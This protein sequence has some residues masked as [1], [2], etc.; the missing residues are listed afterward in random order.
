MWLAIWLYYQLVYPRTAGK[1]NALEGKTIKTTIDATGV[2]SS[3]DTTSSRFAW[4][5]IEW[6]DETGEHYFL[7]P[8][9]LVVLVIPKRAL[10][11]ADEEQR[12]T[13][14]LKDWTGGK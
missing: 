6:V 13:D 8:S 11:G 10:S 2:L 9:S 5:A 4:A 7:W 12:F 14:A 3:T 1:R